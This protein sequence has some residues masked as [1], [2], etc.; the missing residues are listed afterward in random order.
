MSILA[1]FALGLLVEGFFV[2]LWSFVAGVIE[3]ENDGL[4]WAVV[5]GLAWTVDSIIL[6]PITTIWGWIRTGIWIFY[7][8]QKW[9][10]PQED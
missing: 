4:T 2:G 1:C 7:K 8:L 9:S 10:E 6:F 5:D 3:E